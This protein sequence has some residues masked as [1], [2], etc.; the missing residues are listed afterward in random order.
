MNPDP[1]ARVIFP[2]A[3][4]RA[5]IF[6][7]YNGTLFTARAQVNADGSLSPLTDSSAY[8]Y[9]EP[10]AA[11]PDGWTTVRNVSTGKIPQEHAGSFATPDAAMDA[12]I[13][14]ET[15]QRDRLARELND[16]LD[17]VCDEARHTRLAAIWTKASKRP[18]SFDALKRCARTSWRTPST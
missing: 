1:L 5:T 2:D 17:M 8:G 4:G 15:A 14:G 18:S 9:H 16:E 11:Q 3:E 12:A 13:A 7:V 6:T 10:A